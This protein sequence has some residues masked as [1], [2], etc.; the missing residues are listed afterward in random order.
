M[1]RFTV[2][3][4]LF[5]G[6]ILAVGNEEQVAE[7]A[8]YQKEGKLGCFALTEH[9]AGVQSGL[10]CQ[11]T[12]DWDKTTQEFILNTPNFEARKNWI[13][14]GFVAEKALVMADL[15][16][17]GESKGPTAFVTDFRK[18]GELVDG[19]KIDDMG[20]KTTGNDLDNAWITFE[21]VRIPKKSMLSKYAEIIDNEYVVKQKGVRPF[22]MVG[23]RLYSGRIAV[24]GAALAYRRQLYDQTK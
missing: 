13:S 24:A 11:T 17:D 21:N 15:R 9:L 23:Q 19:V 14:Q 5:G 6:T 1:V 18:D 8:D 22:D 16:V 2:H 12:A 4:N 20:R 7:L 10:V 3:Y